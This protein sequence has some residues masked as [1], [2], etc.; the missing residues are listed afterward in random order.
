MVGVRLGVAQKKVVAAAAQGGPGASAGS[1]VGLAAAPG[2][3]RAGIDDGED[4]GLLSRALPFAI[5]KETLTPH[6]FPHKHEDLLG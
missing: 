5:T 2:G 3:E 1:W 6:V 4:N